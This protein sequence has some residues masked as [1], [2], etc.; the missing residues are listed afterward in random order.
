MSRDAMS[1]KATAHVRVGLYSACGTSIQIYLGGGERRRGQRPEQGTEVRGAVCEGAPSRVWGL[2]PGNV[3]KLYIGLQIKICTLCFY[4]GDCPLALRD[5]RQAYT[6]TIFSVFTARCYAL[7]RGYATV[8]RL[9]VHLSVCPS[10]TFNYCDH[11]GWST[12]K[13]ISRPN[14]LRYLLTLTP[15]SV[16]SLIWSNR[17]TPKLGWSRGGVM[18]T[19]TCSTSET[20]QDRTKHDGLK[21]SRIRAFDWHQYQ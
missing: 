14:S 12:S 1:V 20:L 2:I 13:I 3:L 18:S 9:S 10:V 21:G 6:A 16:I 17:N 4:G 11:V 8:C 19:K 7:E 5:Q 15:T